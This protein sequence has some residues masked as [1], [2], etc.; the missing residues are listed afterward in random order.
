MLEKLSKSD[1]E[2][3]K[4]HFDTYCQVTYK[5][6]YPFTLSNVKKYLEQA[7]L[8]FFERNDDEVEKGEHFTWDDIDNLICNISVKHNNAKDTTVFIKDGRLFNDCLMTEYN[9]SLVLW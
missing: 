1:Y 4:T 2:I 5:R 6:F 9:D 3:L 7:V 8:F